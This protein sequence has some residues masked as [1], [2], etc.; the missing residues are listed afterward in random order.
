MSAEDTGQEG[1]EQTPASEG[2]QAPDPMETLRQELKNTKSESA[3]K[4]DNIQAQLAELAAALRPKPQE[5]PV[6]K[7]LIYD[8]PDKYAQIIE[9]RAVAKAEQRVLGKVQQQNSYQMKV[10]AMQADFPEFKDES[11]EA[12]R[13]ANQEY[14][15]LPAHLQ[16]TTEGL[17]IAMQRAA[18]KTGLVPASK[19]RRASTEDYIPPTTNTGRRAPPP[20]DDTDPKAVE[21]AKIMAVATGRNPN[22]PKMLERV[23]EAAKRKSWKTFSEGEES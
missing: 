14:Q 22:D 1:Q 18:L 23:K 8:D 4:M 16:G 7:N 12:Y 11:S 19:R 3:R 10:A 17:E 13:L 15:Q 20:K 6:D 21:F 2:E 9:E 5:T